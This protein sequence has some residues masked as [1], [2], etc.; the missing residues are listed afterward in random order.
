ME[1]NEKGFLDRSKYLVFNGF[2]ITFNKVGSIYLNEIAF[3]N[4]CLSVFIYRAKLT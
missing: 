1:I 2:Q 3:I 4:C